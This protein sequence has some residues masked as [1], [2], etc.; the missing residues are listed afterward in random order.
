[1][2]QLVE[3]FALMPWFGK[4]RPRTQ[5]ILCSQLTLEGAEAGALLSTQVCDD[6]THAHH[7]DTISSRIQAAW[8]RVIPC[9]VL[10]ARGSV[11]T[12]T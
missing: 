3:A 5:E 7:P 4:L 1:M 8:S 11:E 9:V 6:D 12:P 2:A 10:P